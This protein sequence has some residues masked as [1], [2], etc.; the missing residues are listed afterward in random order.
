[1]FFKTIDLLRKGEICEPAEKPVLT[2]LGTLESLSGYGLG[3]L[4]SNLI[5]MVG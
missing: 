3:T 2:L 1:M 4:H 5:R